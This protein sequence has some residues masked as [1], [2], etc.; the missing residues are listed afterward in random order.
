MYIGGRHPNDTHHILFKTMAGSNE[1]SKAPEKIAG[2]MTWGL[3]MAG[4]AFTK[5]GAIRTASLLIQGGTAAASLT[6]VGIGLRV[7]WWLGSGYIISKVFEHGTGKGT[8]GNFAEDIEAMS[9]ASYAGQ[10]SYAEA[11][12]VKF[13]E[14]NSSNTNSNSGENNQVPIQYIDFPDYDIYADGL[15]DGHASDDQADPSETRTSTQNTENNQTIWHRDNGGMTD[16][17]L[18]YQNGSEKGYWE[19]EYNQDGEETGGT[20]RVT[21]MK[22]VNE[23]GEETGNFIKTTTTTDADGKTT[24]TQ[25]TVE[26]KD[27]D[28]DGVPDSADAAPSDSSTWTPNPMNDNGDTSNYGGEHDGLR[29]F[30]GDIDYGP[31]GKPGRGYNG[32]HDE[33]SGFNPRV[34][35]GPDGKPGQ[36]YNGEHDGLIGFNP[37]IDWDRDHNNDQEY[38]SNPLIERLG[39]INPRAIKEALKETSIA[40]NG[41]HAKKMGR[42]DSEF[43]FDAK[44]GLLYHNANGSNKDFG[45]GGAIAEFEVDQD[46][47]ILSVDFL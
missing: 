8:L 45:S 46:L 16:G 3:N 37:R 12:G 34:D 14:N 26:G 21:Y 40:N 29:G 24:T 1:A 9:N 15:V 7:A 2:Y 19:K 4:Q 39:K 20:R 6:P 35:Y 33:L 42:T 30:R 28:G 23:E 22:E 31:D 36:G 27:S 5:T 38:E 17:R 32:E 25:E 10:K 43:I 44:V 13:K 41:R 18:M 11:W 47:S